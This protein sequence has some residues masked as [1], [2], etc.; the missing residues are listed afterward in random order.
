MRGADDK[1]SLRYWSKE[2]IS[3]CLGSLQL[4]PHLS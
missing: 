1:K 4:Q 3:N 2:A